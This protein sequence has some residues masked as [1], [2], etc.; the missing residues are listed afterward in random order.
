MLKQHKYLD[1]EG[2]ITDHFLR[3][4]KQ[5]F[6]KELEKVKHCEHIFDTLHSKISKF[7]SLVAKIEL[8]HLR[9]F[10]KDQGFGFKICQIPR[11]AKLPIRVASHFLNGLVFRKKNGIPQVFQPI[12]L[13]FM[14]VRHTSALM[15]FMI[16][17]VS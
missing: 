10:L 9:Q 2:R 12:P 11:S 16:Q 8:L 1:A 4:T 7:D 6:C 5:Q 13:L 14:K 17:E 15:G 3:A